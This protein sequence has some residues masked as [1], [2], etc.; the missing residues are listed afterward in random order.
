MHLGLRV[1]FST[2]RKSQKVQ[3]SWIMHTAI[4]CTS[5]LGIRSSTE[6]WTDLILSLTKNIP[7]SSCAIRQASAAGESAADAYRKTALEDRACAQP[8]RAV[9]DAAAAASGKTV[10]KSALS[11]TEPP[12]T[13]VIMLESN[14]TAFTVE[15]CMHRERARLIFYIVAVASVPQ[16]KRAHPSIFRCFPLSVENSLNDF[17][18]VRAHEIRSNS[19]QVPT[20]PRDGGG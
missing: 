4:M 15:R 6:P 17:W 14:R 2:N 16:M 12:D 18:H 10:F 1:F 7:D 9:R 8:R 11:T 5:L 3:M 20:S 13:H 19:V